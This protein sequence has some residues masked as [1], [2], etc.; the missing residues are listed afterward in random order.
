VLDLP[1]P[2]H[3][4]LLSGVFAVLAFVV[5]LAQ[6]LGDWRSKK[7]AQ[8]LGVISL[9]L[10]VSWLYLGCLW[11]FNVDL[12]A[13]F[14]WNSPTLWVV[15]GAV[16]LAGVSLSVMKGN[17]FRIQRRATETIITGP[18][19]IDLEVTNHPEKT[20]SPGLIIRVH[21]RRDSDAG[22]SVLV[23]DVRSLNKSTG[24]YR[25]SSGSPNLARSV[26]AKGKIKSGSPSDN[27]WLVRI[28]GDHLEVGN[29]TG[30]GRLDWPPLDKRTT[31]RWKVCLEVKTDGSPDWSKEFDVE[32][33]ERSDTIWIIR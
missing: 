7:V 10:L 22:V 21:N 11:V 12:R 8:V 5:T 2:I 15:A 17:W 30:S 18:D 13:S 6:R 31:Q 27:Q 29:T 4:A 23:R 16:T 3:V 14:S 1:S 33:Q 32:W 26:I 24:A 19:L 25:N 20:R 28:A 9:L